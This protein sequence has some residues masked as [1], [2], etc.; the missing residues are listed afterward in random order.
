MNTPAQVDEVR[1]PTTDSA[2]FD[3]AG[4][5]DFRSDRQ[6]FLSRN[7]ERSEWRTVVI[8]GTGRSGTTMTAGVLMLLG[9]EF[10][11]TTDHR[12]GDREISQCF[13]QVYRSSFHWRAL[14]LRHCFGTVVKG[15]V[16]RWKR[17][18]FK[19]PDLAPFLPILKG[20]IPAPIYIV[21]SRN[22]LE[23]SFGFSRH[24]GGSWRRSYFTV[25]LIQCFLTAF[26]LLTRRPVLTFSY[27]TAI[28]DPDLFVDVLC[29]FLSLEPSEA[30]R[31]RAVEHV[32]PSSG[33]KLLR[34]TNGQVDIAERTRLAGWVVDATSPADAASITVLCEN[35]TLATVRADIERAD[36]K[37]SGWHPTGFCGFDI[38]FDP[39]LT[40][41]Q[42][43]RL[44]VVV[45][46]SSHVL[47]R[48]E[49]QTC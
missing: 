3:L 1:E 30:A 29:R 39:P 21:T 25:T 20:T 43:E 42:F 41:E 5:E 14:R 11:D 24:V 2:P 44:S 17:F 36:V 13:Q 28:K 19:S 26:T 49:P 15:R 8:L 32:D 18:A 27:E 4:F 16:N 7:G 40:D 48:Y 46:S 10:G 6:F 31:A 34:R 12:L 23:T 22:I 33:Y 9:V 35:D 45:E 37:A 47:W 38:T